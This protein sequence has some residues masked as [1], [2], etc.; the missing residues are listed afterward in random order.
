MFVVGLFVTFPMSQRAIAAG[1]SPGAAR[2]A[3]L[4]C[5]VAVLIIVWPL[6]KS[7]LAGIRGG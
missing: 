6:A 7:L 2:A 1:A 4:M 5:I 3:Q